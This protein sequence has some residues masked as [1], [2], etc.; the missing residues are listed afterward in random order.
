MK[1]NR[2][3]TLVELLVAIGILAMVAVLGWRGLDGI[4]RARAALTDQ[5]EMTRGMQLAFA[6][7]QSDCEHAASASV[8]GRRPFLLGEDNRLTLVRTV[9]NENEPARLQV[10]AYRLVNGA[11]LRR[12]SIATRDLLQLDALWQAS[13]SDLDTTGAVTLQRNVESM[14]VLVWQNNGWRRQAEAAAQGGIAQPIGGLQVVLATRGYP[15]PLTKSFL[16]GSI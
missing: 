9:F 16:L 2:G 5:M 12:E 10:I 6:Q 13:V 8:L 11:L 3:F 7:M 4:V 1:R 14:G 15:Q